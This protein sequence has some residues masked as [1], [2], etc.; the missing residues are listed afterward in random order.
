M[1]ENKEEM[2]NETS[3]ATDFVTVRFT[4]IQSLAL[5]DFLM[6][7]STLFHSIN[8]TKTKK[9]DDLAYLFHKAAIKAIIT[10]EN[11]YEF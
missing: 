1:K 8:S 7:L 11:N 3:G 2:V 4:A 9:I 6:N 10:K 5:Y